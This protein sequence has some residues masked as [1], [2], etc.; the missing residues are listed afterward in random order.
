MGG[1]SWKARNGKKWWTPS[2]PWGRR[3]SYGN[4]RPLGD[5]RSPARRMALVMVGR[6]VEHNLNKPKNGL[7]FGV[8]F[9]RPARA[10]EAAIDEAKRITPESAINGATTSGY[11]AHMWV[12]GL[13]M[14]LPAP[15]D[16]R[17]NRG[18]REKHAVRQ[19]RNFLVRLFFA[20]SGEAYWKAEPLTA[21]SVLVLTNVPTKAMTHRSV[22]YGKR[23]ESSPN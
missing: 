8:H 16:A 1:K 19:T 2:A 7:D 22:N 4:G 10:R 5:L 11:A 17:P 23:N 13:D 14:S 12:V 9:R 6:P 18:A 20:D 15:P 3:S 21:E